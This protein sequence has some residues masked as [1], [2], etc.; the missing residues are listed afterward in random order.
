MKL[1]FFRLMYFE[2]IDLVTE[3]FSQLVYDYDNRWNLFFCVC[4]FLSTPQL[5]THITA[6]C[7][8][9]SLVRL[10][11]FTPCNCVCHTK[12]VY[13]FYFPHSKCVKD[14]EFFGFKS[15]A[16]FGENNSIQFQANGQRQNRA[17]FRFFVRLKGNS[18]KGF[19]FEEY[20]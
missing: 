13:S 6:Y 19:P 14:K 8:H 16:N 1:T 9:I 12:L 18:R 17:A 7:C 10:K 20:A 11:T 15:F 4:R 3:W 5:Q 2:V